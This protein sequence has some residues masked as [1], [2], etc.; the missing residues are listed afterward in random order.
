MTTLK[1]LPNRIPI[2]AGNTMIAEINSAPAIGIITAIATPVITLNIM[3]I[4]WTGNPS[5]WAVSSSNV[6]TYIG[7][8]NKKNNIPITTNSIPKK[9]TCSHVMVTIEPNK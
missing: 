4:Q 8:L 7:R 3:D 2:A 6:R 9:M 1:L 5:T